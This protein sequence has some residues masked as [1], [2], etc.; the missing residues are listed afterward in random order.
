MFWGGK[1]VLITGGHG[2]LGNKVYQLLNDK[3]CACIER[4]LAMFY[5][6]RDREDAKQVF[7]WVKPDV[8]INLAGIVGGINYNIKNPAT[9]LNDNLRIALNVYEMCKNY[10]VK[11][12][13]SVGSVCS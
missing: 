9:L 6:I 13:V 3:K 11:Y 10:H 2:F 5:D 8:V 12:L 7:Y 4:P 1:R